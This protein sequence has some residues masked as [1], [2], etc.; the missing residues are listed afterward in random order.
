MLCYVISCYVCMYV[1]I[2]IYMTIYSPSAGEESESLRSRVPQILIFKYRQICTTTGRGS[3]KFLRH[4]WY[5]I[6]GICTIWSKIKQGNE[7]ELADL[8][9]HAKIIPGF[10]PRWALSW[11][12]SC[13]AVPA[14]LVFG[15]GCL[16]RGRGARKTQ[17][18]A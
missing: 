7:V 11:P 8:T 15:L 13:V 6:A 1:C 2:Y 12:E 18:R 17:K 4:S 16:Q 5:C 3:L 14:T 10:W 9:S